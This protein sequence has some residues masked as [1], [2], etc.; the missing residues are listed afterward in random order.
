MLSLQKEEKNSNVEKYVEDS[1]RTV[2]VKCRGASHIKANKP[3][4]DAFLVRTIKEGSAILLSVSDGHGGDKYDLSEKGAEFAAKVSLDIIESYKPYYYSVPD[5]IDIFNNNFPRR[6]VTSWHERVI[7]DIKSSDMPFYEKNKEN[8]RLIYQRYGCTL[9]TALITEGKIYICQIGDGDAMI[10]FDDGSIEYPIPEPI[11]LVGGETH[12]MSSEDSIRLWISKTVT[13]NGK[14][15]IILSTDGLSNSFESKDEVNKF[16]K[17]LYENMKNYNVV[18]IADSLEGWIQKA[19]ENG[20]GDDIT[21]V[22]SIF[23]DES[24]D[25][26]LSKSSESVEKRKE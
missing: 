17:S 15:M 9:V 21:L 8:P 6:I 11:G 4:Q 20:S 1:P 13:I 7:E 19:S 5:M 12:S 24:E 16:N 10:V 3:C 2:A 25:D 22:A 18:N 26:S 23:G 14:G